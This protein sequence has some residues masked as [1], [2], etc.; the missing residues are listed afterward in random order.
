MYSIFNLHD[1]VNLKYPKI[2][3]DSTGYQAQCHREILK[4]L[5]AFQIAEILYVLFLKKNI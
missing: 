5:Y 1:V 2:K 4:T 3:S